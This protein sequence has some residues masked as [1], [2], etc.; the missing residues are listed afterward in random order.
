MVSKLL[1]APLLAL[2]LSAS[3][4]SQVTI[5]GPVSLT[6]AVSTTTGFPSPPAGAEHF[7]NLQ[8]SS[9]TWSQTDTSAAGSQAGCTTGVGTITYGVASPSLSGASLEVTHPNTSG[10]YCNMLSYLKLGCGT[11]TGGCQPTGLRYFIEDFYVYFPSSNTGIMQ[12]YEYDPDL[13]DGTD[14]Y[15]ASF[16]ASTV[17]VDC[18]STGTECWGLWNTAGNAWVK[19]NVDASSFIAATNTWH[20]MQIYGYWDRATNSYTYIDIYVDGS[21]VFQ[22][23][24]QTYTDLGDTTTN[25]LQMEFQLDGNQTAGTVTEYLDNA[26]FYDWNG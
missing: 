11:L 10:Y 22:N 25:T 1:V 19:T 17:S 6:G 12:Q 4:C 3:A 2:S 13:F 20:H 24:N 14:R 7:A 8:S 23:I 5:S 21:P 16:R 9:Y 18:L 15:F 26:N